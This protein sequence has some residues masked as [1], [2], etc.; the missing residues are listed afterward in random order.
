MTYA[1]SCVIPAQLC[2]DIYIYIY[3][4][5]TLRSGSKKFL[6]ALDFFV[7]FFWTL[8]V[9]AVC[10][11]MKKKYPWASRLEE[12][13]D[14]WW[15]LV[16]KSTEQKETYRQ[17]GQ[18]FKTRERGA[19]AYFVYPELFLLW[20]IFLYRMFQHFYIFVS[21]FARRDFVSTYV[22]HFIWNII[23]VRERVPK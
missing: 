16:L 6:S 20:S 12:L 23:Y 5:V 19:V 17:A 8:V 9:E 18:I 21:K 4:R 3:M 10:T 13:T 22:K 2:L 11:N 15:P 7:L 1:C 14:G